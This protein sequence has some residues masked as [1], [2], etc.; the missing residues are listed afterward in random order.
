MLSVS[1]QSHVHKPQKRSVSFTPEVNAKE[2]QSDII[3][4][5]K[6]SDLIWKSDRSMSVELIKKAIQDVD[7]SF[8]KGSFEYNKLMA[9]CLIKQCL[10]CIPKDRGPILKMANQLDPT[11]EKFSEVRGLPF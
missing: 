11:T 7:V 8:K 1:P 10:R 3:Q 9:K 5:L 2:I 4:L 6:N